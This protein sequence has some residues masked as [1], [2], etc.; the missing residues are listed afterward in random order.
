M[1]P[2]LSLAGARSCAEPE[3]GRID[4]D[5]DA[6]AITQPGRIGHAV[7]QLPGLCGDLRVRDRAQTIERGAGEVDQQVLEHVL[8]K[9][10]DELLLAEV[11]VIDVGLILLLGAEQLFLGQAS[12]G[13]HDRGVGDAPALVRRREEPPFV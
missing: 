12:H 13:V 8:D 5:E 9:A 2:P 11:R 1:C 4:G 3:I 6:L 10:R 7:E